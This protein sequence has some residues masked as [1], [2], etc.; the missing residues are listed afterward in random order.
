[1]GVQNLC[2]II[3]VAALCLQFRVLYSQSLTCDAGDLRALQDL[4]KGLESGI[5]GWGGNSSTNCCDW[6]GVSCNSSASLGLS[7]GASGSERVVQLVLGSRRLIGNLSSAVG[8]LDQLRLLNL[9]RNS[10]Q[11]GIPSSVLR[12]PNLEALDLSYNDLSGPVPASIYLPSI[13][14]FDISQNSFS[15]PLPVGICANSTRIRFLNLSVNYFS[16]DIP[17]GL[18]NCRLLEDLR[19]GTNDLTG[20]IP[21]DIFGL[22]RLARFLIQDNKLAG[23]LSSGIG[24]LSHLVK[25]DLSL[26]MFLGN[27]PDV[28]GNMRSLQYFI[29]HSNGFN[30]SIP[31]SLSN[32]E[33][34]VFLN[35]RNNSLAGSI[36]LNCTAMTSLGSLDL[37]SNSF[38]GPL[39]NNLP[40]CR[41]LR[42]INL[43]RNSFSGEIPSTFGNFQSL[44]YL[45][46]SNSSLTNLSSALGI[47]QQCRN[48][49]YLVLTWNFYDELLPAGSTLNFPNLRVLIAAN[50]RLQGPV[51]EWLNKSTNLQLLDLSWNRLSG[52]V[53]SWFGSFQSLFYLDLSNNSLTGE[54]PKEITSLP[55]LINRNISLEE[56][57]PDFPL[58]MKR[59]VSARGLQYNQVLNLPPTL[60]LGYNSLSGSIWPQFGNLKKLHILD[61]RNNFLSGS[62]PDSLSGMTSLEA[63][64][65]SC[66]NLSGTL[67][68]SLTRLNFLSKFTVAHNNLWGPIPIG[69]QFATFPN[70]SFEGTNLCGDHA[71]PCPADQDRNASSKTSHQSNR[72]GKIV[73][74]AVGVVVGTIFILGLMILIV[75][76]THN[77]GEVDPEKEEG[78]Y[79]NR[80]I[81]EQ[82]SQLLVMFEHMESTDEKLLYEDISRATENFEQKN[83]VGCGGF[84]MVYKA[85]LPDGSKLAIKKLSGDCGQMER[86]FQAEVEALSRARHPNLVPL[87]GYCMDGEVRLL[88]YSYMENGS[89]DYWLHEKPDGPAKMDWSTRLK[90]ARGAA[91]GLAYL[92][93]SCE[94]HILHRDIK[95]SNILLDQDFEAHLADFGL[96]RLICAYDTHVTTDLVGTLGYIP[97]E[98]GQA[99]VATYKGDVYSF[100]VVLL[101]LLTGKRPMDICKPKGSRDLISWVIQMK[102]DGRE[103]EVFDQ[104]IYGKQ[105][106]KEI[107]RVF[108]IACCCL[109][110]SPKDRPLTQLL[111]SWL[112]KV[113]SDC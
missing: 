41:S 74:M 64:D 19:L 60:D 100:G 10:L 5:D 17:P 76:R 37:G 69:T 13:Q 53:P 105:H 102:R 63:L 52:P 95:T 112:E 46:L 59:N 32:S 34:L 20:S 79:C 106:D 25:L 93:Q 45:S 28:F 62:I 42:N 49:T 82:E 78:R 50:S 6:P 29:G 88:I 27:I 87:Q 38:D 111:V 57:S 3:I 103:G 113:D 94:P 101:E 9:S 15:G 7:D 40:E 44:V 43:A 67:P 2:L 55:S 107:L 18:G 35:L 108:E 109:N 26:N 110:N 104:N 8:D 1:M 71:P 96:A 84:G 86:E 21:E 33:T 91:S 99:S 58:F 31:S 14:F 72:S 11:K 90:I 75:W 66:N 73:G 30:G 70:S 61:F 4:M 48:L 39:P 12:L 65:L 36:N 77:P 68:S 56:P 98:Y 80:D 81:K 47:L 83:I 89:L 97:P 22:G 54:I 16:G 51:P 92:H 24:N 23:P 85:T